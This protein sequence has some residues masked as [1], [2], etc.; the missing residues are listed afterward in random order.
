VEEGQLQQAAAS[1]RKA[2]IADEA[3]AEAKRDE[4][5]A[6]LREA[7]RA[8]AED[9]GAA[10]ARAER[11]ESAAKRQQD[12]EHATA[13]RQAHQQEVA[14]REAAERRADALAE[15]RLDQAEEI[16]ADADSSEQEETAE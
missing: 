5:T 11:A 4:A 12:R 7:S 9:Q 13:D 3:V 16:A 1:D 2:A 10:R 14:G 6:E 15:T 8:A